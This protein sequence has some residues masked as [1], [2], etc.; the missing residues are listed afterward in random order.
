M[1]KRIGANEQSRGR[2][3]RTLTW[4]RTRE[5]AAKRTPRR[6]LLGSWP[7]LFVLSLAT[8]A[9][10]CNTA[11]AQTSQT[12]T[13]NALA[14]KTYG[15]APFTVSATASSGLTVS[16]ASLTT[17]VC[18]V[19]GTTVTIVAAGTCTI[20][21]SQAG[22]GTYA[23]APNV[24]QSF[25]VAKANQ[26]ITFGALSGKTY[27]AAPFTI[28]A[29]A[30]SGL[31]VT[32]V[33]TT[34]AVCT[35]S[36]AT[37]TIIAA[38]TCTIQAQQAGNGNYNAA[39]NVNQSFTVA[40]ASQTITFGA[41]SGK[42][43]GAAPFTVSATASSGLTVTFVSTT[44]AVCTVSGTTVTIVA[45]GT[46][47]IQARQA[48]NGNYLAAPNVNQS[49]T[50]A[51]A[52]Q[53]ITFGALS[54]KTYGAAPFTVSATA[55]SG[56]AVTFSSLTTPVCTVSGTT[57]TIVGGGTCTIQ[58]AQAG[59]GNYN[60]A[61]NVS[62][63]FTVAKANQTITFGALSNRTYGAAPFTL[64]AT[65]SSGLAVTFSSLTTSVCTT[66]GTTVTLVTAGTCT[67]QAAQA[68]NGN[69]NA[70]PSVSQSFTV[71]AA[72]QTITF[73]SPGNQLITASP[74]SLSAT[75]SSG[76]AVSFSAL[77]SAVC[78]VSG[79]TA[80]LVAP[81]EC[82][83]QAAQP[84]NGS[85]SAAPNVNQTFA[86]ISVPQ[87]SG[88]F[89]YATGS[90]PTAIAAGDFT[91]DGIPDLAIAN[92]FGGSVS[93]FLGNGD[94]A[95]TSGVDVQVGG[96]PAAVA[97]ADF[98]GDGKLDLAIADSF[99]NRVV[100][101][102]GSGNGTFVQAATV[103]A[104]LVP[105]SIAVADLNG[106]GKL[107]LAVANGTMGGTTGQTVTVVLG[108]GNGTF[109]A[110]VSYTTGPTPY[111]VVSGDFNGDGKLDLAV[112]NGDNNTLSVLLG[113]GDGTFAAAVNYATNSYPDGLAVGDFNGDGKLDVAV[114]NDFSDDVSIFL[115]HG[116]GTVGAATNYAARSGP[117]SVAIADFNGDGRVD[118]VVSN[119][120]D[121]T[122]VVLL[123]NGD[124]TFQAA[125]TYNVGAHPNAVIAKDLN[126]DGKPD[127]VAANANDNTLSVLMNTAPGTQAP[128]F[129]SSAP[130]NGTFN[131]PYAFAVTASGSP[132]PTFA[133]TS[134]ALP[135]G[136]ALNAATGVISG[137]PNAGS[138]FAGILT[139]SNGIAPNATQAFNIVIA[140]AAQT[141]SFGTL[142]NQV[143]SATPISLTATASSG[144]AVSFAS[145][146]TSV[147]TVA[148]N[149]V[150]L[151]TV[152]TCTIQATQV[153]NANYS[154]APS[155]NQSFTVTQ[156]SQ[157]IT[158]GALSNQTLGAAPFTVNA[159]AS[160]GLAVSFASLTTSVCTVSGNTVTLV[161]VGTCTVRASQAGNA[162][163]TAAPNVDQSFTVLTAQTITFGAL[164][165]RVFN[166]G[167]F[168]LSATASSGLAVSFSSLT[169]S[170]C[171]VSGTTLTLVAVGT[172]TVRASQAGNATYAPAPNVD[173]SFSIANQVIT[174]YPLSEQASGSP[175]FAV[176]A[177]ANSGLAVAFS[178]LTTPVCTVSGS[179]VTLVAV[180]TCTIRASQA[181]NANY[182]AAANVDQSFAVVTTVTGTIQYAYDAAGRLIFVYAPS[183]DAAQ[184]V[185]D[186]AGNITQINRF[187]AGTI[188]IAQFAPTSGLSGTPVTL[189]GVG[190]NATPSA[191]TVKLNGTVATVSSG[192]VS[193][194]VVT[195]PAG[196]TTGPI[197]VTN[198][199]NTAT[200]S[201][202]FTVG[203]GPTIASFTPTIGV[204]GTS[205]TISGTNFAPVASNDTVGFNQATTTATTASPT[206]L[207]LSVPAGAASGRITVTTPSGSVTSSADFVV[208]P[209][210]YTATSVAATSRLVVDGG[211]TQVVIP[212]NKI[213]VVVFDATAG[214]NLGFGLSG[215]ANSIG[216][217]TILKPDGSVLVPA[218]NFPNG[219]A[220][221]LTV[222]QDGPGLSLDLP[223][224]PVTGTYT[225]LITANPQNG[226]SIAVDLRLSSD[227]TGTFAG[228]GSTVTFKTD[229]F[230]QRGRYTFSGTA[231]Q[232]LGVTFA[233]NIF[234]TLRYVNI[235]N[236][237]S[238]T[239]IAKL[240]KPDGSVLTTAYASA[241]YAAGPS[242]YLAP[243]TLPTTGTYTLYLSPV[244]D[245]VGQMDAK[246]GAFD[247]SVSNLSHG[248]VS[249]GGNESYTIPLSFTINNL[250]TL[251]AGV[252]AIYQYD[253]YAP[254]YAYLSTDGTLDTT[255]LAFLASSCSAAAGTSCTVNTSIQLTSFSPGTYTLFLKANGSQQGS[256]WKYSATMPIVESNP[257]NNVQSV[258]VVLP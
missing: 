14:S 85:Y 179:T 190:F 210:P 249:A 100:I 175:P 88:A 97:V 112:V 33:S 205:L 51:K 124:G 230:G 70:A 107:D 184:Y 19:S 3:A 34:T 164:S 131:I 192:T 50:V 116:D 182:P 203:N 110:P 136:L 200:S 241:L 109:Q 188:A 173:Q 217:V 86:V 65:A 46:C 44:T 48:G 94:G 148:G 169:T 75:A 57:V 180:G 140:P 172:C 245:C 231:G 137:T 218:T 120:F 101:F 222:G 7:A 104:G 242:G 133:V 160:S 258:T 4:S 145:L 220:A 31:A 87:F 227:V 58:A 115:G 76:L 223:S 155:V 142:A 122:L 118:L 239:L 16:F 153:G 105:V 151:V 111:A 178:S 257:N 183:G 10:F 67:I 71:A 66:S 80:T 89:S 156:A 252:S 17:S 13:F 229:R 132:A 36:G 99:G 108:N 53:T 106:D 158:F 150:T 213:A 1:V 45:G 209:S 93:V 250:G 103:S 82:T 38:G 198:G 254:N 177:T 119:R 162:N 247:V 83:I 92:A 25:T 22:N 207:S 216:T 214:Q 54:G 232:A 30:S 244:G 52:S 37:V 256:P 240:L 159:A 168:S 163:Y 61:P 114:V 174:F 49:F 237:V 39:P 32:F 181:G 206:S 43:Y 238:N 187:A 64:S 154:A 95:F 12:I 196:A 127:L 243:Q 5:L 69:Y 74:V 63:S 236:T 146:T 81:G 125:L 47:T 96:L 23:P 165:S 2:V 134:G 215:V 138:T 197:S 8:L 202:N 68:G 128:V 11:Q 186:P 228:L 234:C 246:L 225:V 126:G 185:Y 224:M 121:N 56:L 212:P 195:V 78:T 143:F 139:V 41:L 226:S 194:L 129:T 191:N 24:D 29:T 144:L 40:K 201:T 72:S 21:A 60:A 42:T 199:A 167:P 18:T 123:G 90:Y 171:T 152:G 253:L 251:D 170:V 98:N 28:S 6:P 113:N 166:S 193:Q 26:T 204:A 141:I 55:S 79:S 130:S 149:S 176:S 62:Q 147:C 219:I 135:A 161:A 221:G 235:S 20:E 117:A 15:N 84:G 211:I 91:G 9:G 77:S 248:T 255:D 208:P 233:N 157:T 35:V 27:G 59:N 102:S 73:T 189:I